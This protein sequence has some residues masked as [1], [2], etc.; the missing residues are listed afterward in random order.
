MAAAERATGLK[1]QLA[2]AYAEFAESDATLAQ[3]RADLAA[4]EAS[5]C[6]RLSLRRSSRRSSPTPLTKRKLSVT[7]CVR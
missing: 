2:E 3:K 7:H 4:R 1:A 6:W 5:S